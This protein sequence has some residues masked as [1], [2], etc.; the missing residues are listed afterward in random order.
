[1][2]AHYWS[3]SAVQNLSIMSFCISVSRVVSIRSKTFHRLWGLVPMIALFMSC[4]P[5]PSHSSWSHPRFMSLSCWGILRKL[6]G[7]KHSINYCNLILQLPG[8]GNSFTLCTHLSL[9]APIYA[10]VLYDLS[11]RSRMGKISAIQV[12]NLNP[13]FVHTYLATTLRGEVNRDS[14]IRVRQPSS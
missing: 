6:K 14:C 2:T 10:P 7:G 4:W 12:P 1:M 11:H 3:V 8:N 13:S 5:G 9:S